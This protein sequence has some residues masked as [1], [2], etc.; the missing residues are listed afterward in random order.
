M[1]HS[2]VVTS[3]LL[4]T[5]QDPPKSIEPA[6]GSLHLPAPRS[7]ARY[8]AQF[9]GFFVPGFDM[10]YITQLFE[11][12]SYSRRVVAFIQAKI[13]RLFFTRFRAVYDDVAKGRFNQFD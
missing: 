12:F 1:Q 4:P 11:Q 9:G 8:H 3:F 7:I 5:D 6:M 2:Q 13:L 10:A